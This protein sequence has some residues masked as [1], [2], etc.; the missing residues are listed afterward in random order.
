VGLVAGLGYGLGQTAVDVV[1]TI[2]QYALWVSIALIVIVSFRA[3]RRGQ[4][5]TAR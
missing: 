1:L 2:D 5:T 3:G 4:P